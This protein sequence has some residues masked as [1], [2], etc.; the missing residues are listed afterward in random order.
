MI[1]ET[2]GVAIGSAF[3]KRKLEGKIKRLELENEV[4][5]EYIN[6]N[7]RAA[8]APFGALSFFHETHDESSCHECSRLVS[9]FFPEK[10]WKGWAL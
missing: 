4:M 7:R 10:P 9:T 5:R 3:A 2:I 1:A 8:A 6:H